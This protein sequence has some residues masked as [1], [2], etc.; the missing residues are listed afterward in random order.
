MTR[1]KREFGQDIMRQI[2][3]VFERHW[4]EGNPW[5][6]HIFTKSHLVVEHLDILADMR[7]QVQV[8][9]TLTT[10]DEQMRI[11]YEGHAPSVRRRLKA[12]E[13]LSRAG[14]FVRVMG[15]PLFRREDAERILSVGFEHGAKGFKHKGEHYW[16]HGTVI[17]ENP[18]RTKG[19]EYNVYWDL[20]RKSGEP[21]SEKGHPKTVKVPM[22]T[23]KWHEFQARDMV[24]ENLG[25]SELNGI[26]WGYVV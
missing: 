1:T 25:Y 22:P 3:E 11:R 20:L 5:M 13:R 8:E 2:L 10:L 12:I 6:V 21:V 19:P 15:M 23:R 17:D 7:H 16:G 24:V 9:L 4:H 26:D 18:I 14:I